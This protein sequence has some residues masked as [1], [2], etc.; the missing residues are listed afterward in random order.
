MKKLISMVPLVGPA[1]V[2]KMNATKKTRIVKKI[3]ARKI[4]YANHGSE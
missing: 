3:A 2:A 4:R 1:I